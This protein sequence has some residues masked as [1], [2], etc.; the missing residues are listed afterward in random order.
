M[1]E[2]LRVNITHVIILGVLLIALLAVLIFAGILSCN[3]VPKGC[4]IYYMALKGGQ[5]VILIAYSSPEQGEPA[6]LGY[7]KKLEAIL[8]D[9]SILNAQIRTMEIERLS[10]GNINDYDL[11]VV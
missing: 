10:Y 9:R 3:V 6:G 1:D 8:N 7:E 2:T 11:I 5:P 4:E